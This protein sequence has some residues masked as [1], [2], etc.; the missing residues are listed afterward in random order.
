MNKLISLLENMDECMLSAQ[1]IASVSKIVTANTGEYRDKLQT[2]AKNLEEA[3]I[4]IKEKI[5]DS[6]HHLGHVR[7]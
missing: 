2:V 1:A 7:L 4:F 5:S 6:F 3:A